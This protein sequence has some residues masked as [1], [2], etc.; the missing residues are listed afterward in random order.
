MIGFYPTRNESWTPEAS[1]NVS[2]L[3]SSPSA[4]I[5]T[6]LPNVILPTPTYTTPIYTF[7]ASVPAGIGDVVSTG[8]ATSTYSPILSHSPFNF[9][10]LPTVSPSPTLFTFIITDTSGHV[11]AETW[12]FSTPTFTLGVPPGWN[13]GSRRDT[14]LVTLT[15][16]FLIAWCIFYST[17]ICL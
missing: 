6:T 11:V 10:A 12:T 15:L 9:S 7:N 14:S 4:T 3:L 1:P 13:A 8:L 16:P 17:D 2:S 5:A